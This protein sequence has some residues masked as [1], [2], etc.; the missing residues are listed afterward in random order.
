MKSTIVKNVN[1]VLMVG[2]H[3]GA[4]YYVFERVS[5]RLEPEDQL[6]VVMILA[7]LTAA[8]VSLFLKD[9]VR[10]AKFQ[11]RVEEEYT[12]GFSLIT[13]LITI[14]YGATI[15]FIL[16]NYLKNEDIKPE[17][18]KLYVGVIETV[19]GGFVGIVYGELFK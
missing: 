7:P 13:I 3:F 18:L 17:M 8:F 11:V 9:A 2:V 19:I 10:H 1:G 6:A 14:L 16:S 4:I 12:L 5:K 15:F